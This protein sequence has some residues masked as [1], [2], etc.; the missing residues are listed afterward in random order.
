MEQRVI[1]FRGKRIDNGEWICGD[2][3]RY[4]DQAE[5]CILIHK[6]GGFDIIRVAPE[7]V[8]QFAGLHDKNG[9]E[10]YEGDIVKYYTLKRYTQQSHA[11]VS[12]EIDEHYLKVVFDFVIFDRCAFV[13]SKQ[14]V[15]EII[16]P[17][18]ENGL[19]DLGSIKD[20]C[21]CVDD[22]TTDCNGNQINETVLGIEVIGNIYQ[23]PELLNKQHL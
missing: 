15:D 13:L 4:I 17:L 18:N 2:L 20:S 16:W 5:P 23:N 9:K 6:K 14:V 7:T 8:G 19:S 3:I 21:G 12:P 1:K 22:E 11:D 10:I